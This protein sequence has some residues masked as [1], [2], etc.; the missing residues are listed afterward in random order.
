MRMPHA[1]R[2]TQAR[3]GMEGKGKGAR[4]GLA[5]LLRRL[6]LEVGAELLEEVLEEQREQLAPAERGEGAH[7]QEHG[8]ACGRKGH[9]TMRV[10][11]A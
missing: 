1:A 2:R 3:R 5:E 11:F 7:H 4:L 9:A 6:P 8:M 10:T